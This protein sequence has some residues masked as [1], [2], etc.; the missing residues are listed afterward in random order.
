MQADR[1]RLTL[2]LDTSSVFTVFGLVQGDSL[3][4]EEKTQAPL[5]MRDRL[6]H[7]LE[8]F[9]RANEAA[10][11]FIGAIALAIGPGSF[12]GLRVSLALAKGIA[13]AR[14]IPVWPVSSLKILAANAQGFDGTIAT[15]IPARK[16]E[17]YLGLYDGEELL[18]IHDPVCID[19]AELETHV[20]EEAIL[21]GPAVTELSSEIRKRLAAPLSRAHPDFHSP[22]AL[23]LAL[24]A[25]KQWQGEQAPDLDSLSP[26]Y[27]KEFP[28]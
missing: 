10:H 5:Q 21:L 9:L 14:R 18:P 23:R 12:T 7:Q 16:G 22:S 13:Y 17:C 20:A 4:A 2:A 24:L 26:F 27:L 6:P 19:H 25:K 3:L 11:G 15:I 28:G 8:R 1:S